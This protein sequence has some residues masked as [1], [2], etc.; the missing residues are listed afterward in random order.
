[1]APGV[2]AGL[3]LGLESVVGSW[4]HGGVGR[5]GHTSQSLEARKSN[6][7]VTKRLLGREP[8]VGRGPSPVAHRLGGHRAP[9]QSGQPSPAAP[10]V[11]PP[12]LP[13]FLVVSFSLQ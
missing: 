12:S 4:V 11:G 13:T 1:M 10:G 2:G 7:Q 6:V 3:L 9:S 8:R 5:A